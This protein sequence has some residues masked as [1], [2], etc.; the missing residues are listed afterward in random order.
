[1]RNNKMKGFTLVELL[2][3]IAILAIL[4]TVSV[5]GYTSYIQSTT[6]TVDEDFANQLNHLLDAYKVNF[7][8]DI[9]ADNIQEV[10]A[11]L[12][13]EGGI[14]G[15][16][17]PKSVQYGYHFYF[18][19]T[20][21]KYVL[22]GDDDDRINGKSMF[23]MLVFGAGSTQTAYP[24]LAI[25]K[26]ARYFLIETGTD[27]ANLVAEFKAITSAEQLNTYF[28]KVSAYETDA[29]QKLVGLIALLNETVFTTNNGHFIVSGTENH[30]HLFVQND[31]VVSNQNNHEKMSIN[32]SDIINKDAP[33]VTLQKDQTIV[34]SL[35]DGITLAKHSFWFADG[36]KATLVIEGI[37]NIA[38]F[39]KRVDIDFTNAT[40]VVGGVAYTMGEGGAILNE[41]NETVATITEK[42][43]VT[44]FSYTVSNDKA[45]KVDLNNG[46][47]AIDGGTFTLSA[48]NFTGLL[49]N[50]VSTKSVR[51]T[52]K[53][54]YYYTY[55][56]NNTQV[57]HDYTP[58]EFAKFISDPADGQS[59][60]FT[61]TLGDSIPALDGIEIEA[62]SLIG[63]DESAVT[64]T[65]KVLR[66]TGVTGLTLGG[67]PI[68]FG[69]EVNLSNGTTN[70][71]TPY[72]LGDTYTLVY[73]YSQPTTA[74]LDD[75]PVSLTGSTNLKVTD[76]TTITLD[77]KKTELLTAETITVT[78]GKYFSRTFNV[79]MFDALNLSFQAIN[80]KIVLVGDENAI[81]V[82]DLIG[83][84]D[85]FSVPVNAEVWFMKDFGETFAKPGEI[86]A[87][88]MAAGYLAN[89]KIALNDGDAWASTPIEF[90][91]TKGAATKDEAVEIT[92]VIV[93]PDASSSTGYRCI[94]E[95]RTVALVDAVNVKTYADMTASM[96]LTKTDLT[97]GHPLTSNV[98]FLADITM[99]STADFFNIPAGKTVYG[100]T[101]TLNIK[102][103]RKNE[104]GIIHLS[105]RIQD[106]KV[107]GDV[108]TG[109][110]VSVGS[111]WGSAAICTKGANSEIENCYISGCRSPLRV[112]K[113]VKITNSIFYG[114][115]YANIDVVAGNV[116]IKGEVMTINQKDDNYV[117]MG[118][119]FWWS[120][121][122]DVSKVIIDKDEDGNEI[123]KLTQYNFLSQNDAGAMPKI[124][125]TELAREANVSIND[126][127]AKYLP[128]IGID[129]GGIFTNKIMG[130]SAYADGVFVKNNIKYVN[131][132]VVYISEPADSEGAVFQHLGKYASSSY[133]YD[134]ED[135]IYIAS[136]LDSNKPSATLN[137][138]VVDLFQSVLSKKTGIETLPIFINSL[139]SQYLPEGATEK[140]KDTENYAFLD[141]ALANADKYGASY[142]FGADGQI[143]TY[144]K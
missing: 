54:A 46:F 100:N 116:Y 119:A 7:R 79:S 144:G 95:P 139:K 118:I 10:T 1:M 109:F 68:T 6:I 69:G 45:G 57:R 41:N 107:V 70:G 19:L 3:V 135:E 122:G 35:A 83:K 31:L 85:G 102:A 125:I 13:R 89:T 67:K 114:G 53:A 77:S 81:T 44:S 22:I 136:I 140:V 65:L 27:L 72:T 49:N 82:G 92:L 17:T 138:I 55:D 90:V 91:D 80:D 131:T 24:E 104:A 75:I 9:T 111:N 21:Q 93:V 56:E 51:W 74:K 123:A 8:E 73:N 58:A 117:G 14:S 97:S 96:D 48:D 18:D 112:E 42:N 86:E 133:T 99:D 47:I 34:L 40:V 38:D 128:D 66:A 60:T 113:D 30:K 121:N 84:K 71:N 4:A 132:G 88:G 23:A 141:T 61:I 106:T 76:N 134:P 130:N 110:A 87:K 126:K 105:G 52:V 2:V 5:V 33:L 143:L 78:F 37:D 101:F 124:G 43:R 64:F 15:D 25:T 12:L 28:D 127:I 29:R 32:G 20:E 50:E 26:E 63:T 142:D 103:G 115:R 36:S 62:N 98:V 11:D 59:A 129:L 120:T 137:W 108:Y 39:A 16:L 94:S